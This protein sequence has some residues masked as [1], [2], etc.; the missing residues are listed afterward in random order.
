MDQKTGAEPPYASVEE[1]EALRSVAPPTQ[2]ATFPEI[3]QQQS[4]FLW[5]TLMNLGVPRCDA[6][7]VCQEVMLTVHRR[8]PDFDGRSL[9]G[10]LYGI[11]VRFASDYRRSARVRREVPSES[12]PEQTA[13][14]E[15]TELLDRARSLRRTLAA[16]DTLDDAKR[17]A[18]VL[19]EVEELT[20]AEVSEALAVP[21]QTVYSR[22]KAARE[23][24]RA[25]LAT[26]E[27]APKGG[28]RETG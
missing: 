6:Q 22:V 11:C 5:R 15:S 19:Y 13:S 24:L 18:F 10:W 25:K 27:A 17:D 9:R 1:S 12:L 7:D 28:V 8:L 20:L 26:V 2:A 3:F 16:L 14:S 23:A 21:I 4:Q